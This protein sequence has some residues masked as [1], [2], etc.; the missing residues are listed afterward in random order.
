MFRSLVFLASLAAVF[1]EQ[2]VL[3]ADYGNEDMAAQATIVREGFVYPGGEYG[4][5]RYTY[6]A[7]APLYGQLGGGQFSGGD[8]APLYPQFISPPQVSEYYSPKLIGGQQESKSVYD[9]GR[10]QQNDAQFQNNHGKN[11]QEFEEAQHGFQKGLNALKNAR[12][13]SGS[14]SGEEG[15]RR[16]NEDQKQ[17]FGGRQY[18]KQGNEPKPKFY[19]NRNKM[20]L[21]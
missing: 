7:K 17:Y 8:I 6:S 14:F 1:G 20:F 5:T 16:L 9:E 3:K 13:D 11:G 2:V 10:R 15:A 4:G 18:N 21:L 12:G 19:G